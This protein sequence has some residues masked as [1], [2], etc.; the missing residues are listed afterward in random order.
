MTLASSPS[1]VSCGIAVQSMRDGQRRDL[2]SSCALPVVSILKGMPK[3][4]CFKKRPQSPDELT[5]YIVEHP[6]RGV[7]L[8]TG[9]LNPEDG[10]GMGFYSVLWSDGR[11]EYCSERII[12]ESRLHTAKEAVHTPFS[13]P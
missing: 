5:G 1:T 6:N 2:Q 11:D 12:L 9:Y 4:T 3:E 13:G 10:D 7:G 8:I